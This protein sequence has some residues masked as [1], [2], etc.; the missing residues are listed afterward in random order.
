MRIAVVDDERPA[1]S[2]LKHQILDILPEAEIMEADSGVSAL[3]L[4]AS[5]TFDIIFLDI[6][7]NDMEGTT[8]A[9]AAAGMMPE[10]RIVFATA[11]SEYAVKAFELGVSNYILKPFDPDR[12]K[13]VIEKCISELERKAFFRN[14]TADAEH[15]VRPRTS[16]SSS[17]R[18][19]INTNRKTV[20]LDVEDIAYIETSGRGC[21]VHSK[22]GDYLENQLLG[23][24][25]RRLESFGFFR[26]H[27]SYLVNP[28]AIAELF[29]WANNSLALR[30]Q[31]FEK[32]ILP[33]G[34]DK[35]KALRQI[36]NIV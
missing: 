23:E 11:Y 30:M 1:R 32:E 29:P 6:N 10:A 28:A 17:G 14:G 13:L 36:L 25:E 2:E 3:K 9:A 31:G 24:W 27:K 7:L 4:L 20:L 15:T 21:I 12:L 34:R 35:V 16:H 8:L 5:H 18:I 33:V 19:A 22:T 26:I